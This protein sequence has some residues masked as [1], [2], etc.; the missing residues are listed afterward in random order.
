GG[1]IGDADNAGVAGDA[2][3]VNGIA[4]GIKKVVDAAEKGGA[5][6]EAGDANNTDNKEAGK[7]FAVGNNGANESEIGKAAAAVSL[8]SGDQIL[9]AIVDAAK[10]GDGQHDGKKANEATNAVEAAIGANG[11]AAA[12]GV[13]KLDKKNDQIAAAV[14]LRGLAKDGKFGLSAGNAEK[15]AAVKSLVD[16]DQISKAIVDAAKGDEQQHEG[17]A[18]GEATNA[19]EAAIGGGAAAEFGDGKLDK[20]NDQIAAAVVLRGLAKGGKFGLGGNEDQKKKAVK[21]LV[22]GDQILKAIVGAAKGDKQQHDGK[23]AGEAANAVEAAI[24]NGDAAADFGVDKLDKKNDQIA[25]AVVLRGLA[26]DGKFGLSGAGDEEKKAAV[27]SLVESAT[28]KTFASLTSL[29]RKAVEE[30]LKT[31]SKAVK[32][33]GNGGSIG[34]AAGAGKLEAGDANDTDNA[35]AGKLFA[36]GN[37]GA[38]ESEIG[39]AA[40][41]VSKVIMSSMVVRRLVRLK[42]R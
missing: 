26:K 33:A 9:K 24:G 40:A 19:V 36:V 12:F 22:D 20:K 5:K 32:D 15:K 30:G 13:D 3:S 1:D 23:A 10:G 28:Q 11:A 21:S 41:A 42:M 25:A 17:K 18:A 37:G 2:A 4:N 16:G 7:L 14:V 34:D 39:K 6:L 38:D 31:V 27:K 29:I 8:V 35:G